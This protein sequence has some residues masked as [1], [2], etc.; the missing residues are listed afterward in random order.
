MKIRKGDTVKIITGKD[1]GKQGTVDLVM[2]KKGKIIVKGVNI[3]T[4]HEKK[5]DNKKNPGG[6]IQKEAPINTSNVMLVCPHTGKNTRV[7]Y[8][9]DPK[10]KKKIRI[11]KKSGKAI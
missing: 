9:I 4:K 10:T 5:T 11:S 7:G 6:R 2:P 1:K 3:I 8:K